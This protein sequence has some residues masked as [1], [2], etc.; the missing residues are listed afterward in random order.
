MTEMDRLRE[1]A[2][3]VFNAVGGKPEVSRYYDEREQPSHIDLFL[4]SGRP[5]PGLVTYS[6]IGLSEY[7]LGL[8]TPEGK[9]IHAE[10][11]CL[12]D[13]SE[14]LFAS[15]LTS[16]AFAIMNGQA[17]CEPGAV[18]DHIITLYDDSLA[19][20]Y[21][22]LTSPWWVEDGSLEIERE[23]SYV[24]WLAV[25]PISERELDYLYEYG[26]DAFEDLLAETSPDTA[27]LH[28]ESIV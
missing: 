7:D 2:G 13:S 9:S 6:T 20:K 5:V 17:S 22:Y 4:S 1:V 28:R 11:I 23:D 8:V 3:C 19:V 24:L 12:G 25:V 27:D 14:P 15:I 18:L 10:L 16:C 26:E 21:L